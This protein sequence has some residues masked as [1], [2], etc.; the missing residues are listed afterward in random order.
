MP[1][2][3]P[4][5]AGWFAFG[6]SGELP[7]GKLLARPFMGREVVV[8]RT[9]SGQAAAVDAYCPHLGA[10]FGFGGSVEGELLRCPFHGFCFDGQGNCVRT[11]YGTRPPPRAVLPVYPLCEVNGIL[12]VYHAAHN[13]TP[14]WEVPALEQ[15]GWTTL[16]HRVF[17]LHDHPQ[18]TTENSVDLG[19]FSFVHGYRRPRMLGE[20]VIDGPHLSTAFMVSRGIPG[21][22]K[23]LPQIDFDFQ[24]ET[25]IYGLGYSLVNVQVPA[26]GLRARLWVLPTAVDETHID[27]RLA[28]SVQHLPAG[29]LATRLA[30]DILFQSFIHDTS[31]DFTIW[32]NKRYTDPPALAPGDG[33]IGKYRQWAKQ[34]YPKIW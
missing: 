19:H 23:L 18:E 33:P 30:G 25:Q 4:Y 3:P 9:Q 16:R 34:F 11:G 31:Q 14:A 13:E 8:F 10:H 6:F 15:T 29:R 5:P 27:L 28:C 12:M 2:L 32:E 22:E 17:R 21:L 26:V 24:F 1:T 7:P 20:A